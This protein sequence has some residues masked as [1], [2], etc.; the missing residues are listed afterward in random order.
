MTGQQHVDGDPYCECLDCE[1]AHDPRATWEAAAGSDDT[2]GNRQWKLAEWARRNGP[3]LMDRVAALEERARDS[4]NA[5][6]AMVLHCPECGGRH[7]DEGAWA[8]R[9]HHTHACQHCGFVWRPA[10]VN[11]VGVRFLPGF[12]S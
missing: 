2:K 6:V 8:T 1:I 3:R 11:T 5:S 12:R 9:P 4:A 7:I 10:V